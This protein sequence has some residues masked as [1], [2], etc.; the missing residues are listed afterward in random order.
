MDGNET[1]DPV[2]FLTAIVEASVG[3]L[4][5]T[6]VVV[7]LGRDSGSS[8]AVDKT[9]MM[10][11]LGWSSIT[12]GST[13]LSLVLI[14]A[15]VQPQLVWRASSLTWL[16]WSV[17]FATWNSVRIFRGRPYD[18]SVVVYI[19]AV[20]IF[21]LAAGMLQIGNVAL[22]SAFWPHF[23]SLAVGLGLGLSQFIRFFWI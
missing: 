12:L 17:P 19:A 23:F 3:L 7:A 11:L 20:Y 6:G 14:S 10:N 4:G 22:W 5:F 8:S 13:L 18:S 15:E 21:I 2:E 9:R 1:M 16:L